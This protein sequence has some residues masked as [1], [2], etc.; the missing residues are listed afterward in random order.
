MRPLLDRHHLLLL[1][2]LGACGG[3][4]AKT[5]TFLNKGTLLCKDEDDDGECDGSRLGGFGDGIVVNGPEGDDHHPIPYLVAAELGLLV[6]GAAFEGLALPLP[7]DEAQRG[8]VVL[9]NRLPDAGEEWSDLSDLDAAASLIGG[10]AGDQFGSVVTGF[11]GQLFVGAPGVSIASDE[12]AGTAYSYDDIDGASGDVGPAAGTAWTAED[13]STD[14]AFGFAI[15]AFAGGGFVAMSAPGE[16]GLIS[17]FSE[18]GRDGGAIA[19]YQSATDRAY[20][21]LVMAGGTDLVIGLPGTNTVCVL[22]AGSVAPSDGV[23]VLEEE[24]ACFEGPEGFGDAVAIGDSRDG[25]VVAAGAWG[26]EDGTGAA[27]YTTID[28][29]QRGAAAGTSLE[30]TAFSVVGDDFGDR[31][32]A[33]V[34]IGDRGDLLIGAPGAFDGQGAVALLYSAETA[35]IFERLEADPEL[36]GEHPFAADEALIGRDG[37]ALGVA[38]LAGADINGDDLAD[39]AIVGGAGSLVI[40]YGAEPSV[41]EVEVGDDGEIVPVE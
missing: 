24:A 36:D 10:R 39:A 26:Y 9:L 29:W 35:E 30:D 8:R 33:A 38:I 22:D 25:E 32:G 40:V 12:G 28:T 27:Y 3:T 41:V 11:D 37:E 1:P 6:D 4:T 14:A 31:L 34:A 5:T 21:G 13:T 20:P 7:G 17:I 15:A 23:L 19:Q 18:G 2:L 16:A